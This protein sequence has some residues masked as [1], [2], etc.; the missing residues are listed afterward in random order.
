MLVV[1]DGMLGGLVV[2]NLIEVEC[3]GLVDYVGVKFGDC[4]FFLVGLVKLLWVLLGVVC[5]EIVNWLG[6]IDFDVWVFVWVVDLLLFELVD[7]VIVVGEVVVGLGVWIVVYYV[8]IVL[9]LE[10][11]DCIEF[12]IGSVLVD[13][14]DIVCNGYEIG[15]GL[16]CIYCCD[17]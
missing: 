9:K 2:K 5:V 8:F 12:D 15:G 13:V 11:E 16:V 17:I 10:W 4:I 1:E 6:L 14:Y 7:E 3:I